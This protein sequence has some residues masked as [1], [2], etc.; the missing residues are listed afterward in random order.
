MTDDAA[1]AH[2][3]SMV[4]FQ[5]HFAEQHSVIGNL[6]EEGVTNQVNIAGAMAAIEQAQTFAKTAGPLV[7]GVGKI[8]KNIIWGSGVAVRTVDEEKI[9][10]AFN[11]SK[12]F[13]AEIKK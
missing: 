13:V 1:I 8:A 5:A 2:L 9:K 10:A 12:T 11:D 3:S 4:E 6:I 7:Q